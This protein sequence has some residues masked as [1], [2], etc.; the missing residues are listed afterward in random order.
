VRHVLV[1]YGCNNACVFCAQGQLRSST[2]PAAA[3]TAL[4]SD[5]SPGDVV[6]FVGGEPTLSPALLQLV[7]RARALGATEVIV[8]TNGRRLAYADYARALLNAGVTAV[9]VSLHGS[10]SV[11]HEA[12]TRAPGSFGQTV[13]GLGVAVSVGLRTGVSTVVT[14][15]NVRHLADIVRVAHARSVRRVALHALVLSGSALAAAPRL[16]FPDVIAA[17]HILEA[18]RVARRLGVE[19]SDRAD[20]DRA[21]PIFAGLAFPEPIP[22]DVQELRS[23]APPEHRAAS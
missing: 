3:E 12:H 8:Q 15:S 1:G 23:P 5:V 7:S 6:A 11:M 9:D 20:E 17:P 4:L 13:T 10:T 16:L 2:T 21:A 18:R 19:L 22:R 14:R